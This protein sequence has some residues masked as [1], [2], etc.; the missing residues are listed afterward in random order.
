MNAT[1]GALQDGGVSRRRFL[2]SAA[3]VGGGL[4][5]AFIFPAAARA[6]WISAPAGA[7]PGEINA[8]VNVGPD[9]TV[10]FI[11]P[12][13]EMGQGVYTG[14]SQL[15]AEELECDISGI[16]IE[17][18]AVAAV[19]NSP[20]IPAQFTGGSMSISSNWQALRVAGA[21]ARTML[22]EAAAKNWGVDA[23]AC[24]AERNFVYGPDGRKAGYG[25]LAAAAAKIA[26]PDPKD[27]PLKSPSKFVVIG[28]PIARVEVREKVDGSGKFGLDVRVPGMLRAALARPPTQGA[29]AMHIDDKAAL[30]V[31]G[32]V[33]VVPLSVGVAVVAKNTYAAL[34]GRDALLIDWQALPDTTMDTDKLRAQYLDLS[35]HGAALVARND[36]D[37]VSAVQAVG[38]KRVEA[39]YELPYLSHAA[40]EPLNCAAHWRPDRCDLWTGT[41]FQSPDRAAAAQVAGLPPEKV[42][43][44]T[45]LL[46]GGFGR[47]GN[48]ASDFVREAVELSRKIGGPVQIVWS[49]EDDMRGGWYRPMWTNRL[50]AM[51]GRDGKI[52]A[53]HH[54]I[55][56]QSIMAGTIFQG[57]VKNGVDPTSVEG[58]ADM[59][60]DAANVRVDLCT[61][62]APVTVQWWRSVGHSNTA[63]AVESFIDECAAG[64][65]VDPLEYRRSLLTGPNESRHRAV[66]EMLAAKSGWGG[67]LPAG[68]ARGMALHA[69]FGSVV[70]EVA[71]VSMQDGRPRVHRVV[72][73]IHCGLA[74]NPQMIAAQIESAVNYGLSAALYVEIT[75]T[76]GKPDQSNFDNYAVVRISEAPT[77]EVHIVPSEDAPTGVGEP[78]TPPIAPSLA[79]AIFALTG[80][81]VRRL[82]MIRGG[83]FSA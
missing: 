5:L 26:P 38:G 3:E 27:V 10:T 1:S 56:G 31:P 21:T 53:W 47:R 54:T 48:P 29:Q 72:A 46:G 81:R 49:R 69:S 4:M 24:R 13:S 36:G 55:V 12:K 41:Q 18:A 25:A 59:P 32:V 66:L 57:M 50:R 77:V 20:G 30:K 62:T 23:G 34:R 17:T 71:E 70:G 75:Y 68:R 67:P 74:V 8:F 73:V 79:N 76:G 9:G 45:M 64:A 44:H 78:G 11:I 83:K 28:K 61:T 35:R 39:A 14:L 16:R 80:K 52:H 2:V 58:A 7:L 6:A 40:M 42:F 22:I 60:Y 37:A 33:R 51:L 15:L 82:P 43:I 19:Y 65:G 63:F